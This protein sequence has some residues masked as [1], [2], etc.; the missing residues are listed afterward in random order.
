MAIIKN[1]QITNAGQGGE[2]ETLSW[3][4]C[5][6]V[7]PLWRTVQSLHRKDETS[8]LKRYTHSVFTLTLPIASQGV[9]ATYK[10]PSTDEWNKK[11]LYVYANGILCSPKEECHL[12]QEEGQT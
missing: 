3:W 8:N 7:Q 6:L 4:G 2:N 1:L 10:C 9:E 12:Q 5:R 11:M